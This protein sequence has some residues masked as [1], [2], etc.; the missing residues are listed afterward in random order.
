[1]KYINASR[2]LPDELVREIQKYVQGEAVYIP[3]PDG[4]RRRWGEK[5]GNRVQLAERN[6]EIRNRFR[7]GE[8]IVCLAADHFLSE[9]SI[10]KIIYHRNDRNDRNDESRKI[11]PVVA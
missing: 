2:V 4:I 7:N 10:R 1:M 9:D 8:S 3:S 11:D 5:T 6:R